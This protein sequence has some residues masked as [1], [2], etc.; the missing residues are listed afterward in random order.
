MK[1]YHLFAV[2]TS[3]I[4]HWRDDSFPGELHETHEWSHCKY[5]ELDRASC[6]LAATNRNREVGAEVI[7][8]FGDFMLLAGNPLLRIPSILPSAY[9]GPGEMP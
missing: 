6:D 4:V 2:D 1:Q 8:L 7:A 3:A 5:P 9:N